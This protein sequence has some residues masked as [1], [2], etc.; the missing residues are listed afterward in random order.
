MKVKV[1]LFSYLAIQTLMSAAQD[2]DYVLPDSTTKKKERS[3]LQLPI[4]AA[5][6]QP[7]YYVPEY[8]PDNRDETNSGY[9]G[10]DQL[11][12]KNKNDRTSVNLEVGSS[13][14]TDFNG[15]SA[16]STYA[17]PHIRHQIDENLAVS[18]GVMMSQT[19]LNGWTSY[20]LDGGPMPS[21]IYNNMV[22]GRLDYRVNEKLLVYGSVY[23]NLTS[24]PSP[25][26]DRQLDGSGYSLGLEYKMSERSFL[27]IQVSR[28]TGYNPFNPYPA[29]FGFGGRPFS[30]FP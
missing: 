2:Y 7:E 19:F 1:I 12:K 21:V 28:S 27:Q 11:Q 13:V 18:G 4:K 10:D 16:I 17:A 23:K 8:A 5:E 20:S 25:G 15:N 3:T 30:Y 14:S 6:S 29:N 26:L 24:M 9:T 22:Y